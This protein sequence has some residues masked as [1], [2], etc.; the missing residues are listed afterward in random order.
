MARSIRPGTADADDVLVVDA[1]ERTAQETFTAAPPAQAN[2]LVKQLKT[3]QGRRRRTR[4]HPAF[5]RALPQG[6]A[7][8]PAEEH[9]GPDRDRGPGPVAAQDPPAGEETGRDQYRHHHRDPRHLRLPGP[10]RHHRRR[11]PAPPHRPLR[12]APLRC[13]AGHRRPDTEQSDRRRNQKIYFQD[14]GHRTQDLEM[15]FTSIEYVDISY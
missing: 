6:P 4:H 11:P 12:Q 9:R 8:E 13:T 10:R 7:Q 5:R 2:F 1:I 15:E 3:D 14:G